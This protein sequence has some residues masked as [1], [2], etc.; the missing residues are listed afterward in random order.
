MS[1]IMAARCH[2]AMKSDRRSALHTWYIDYS[3]SA[4]TADSDAET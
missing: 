1:A 4:T 2:Y 3:M